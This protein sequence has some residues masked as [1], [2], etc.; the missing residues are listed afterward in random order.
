MNTLEFMPITLESR[1]VIMPFLAQEEFAISDITFGNLYIW[2]VARE[3]S[4]AISYDTLLLQTKY[5]N[6]DPYFFF[7][8]GAGDKAQAL[9]A[10]ESYVKEQGFVL[11][12]ESLESKNLPLLQR[13]FPNLKI[14]AR[15]ERFDYVYSISE[16]IALSGRKYHKKKNH[17]NQFLQ[18]YSGQWHYEPIS[19]QNI[20]AIITAA[21]QWLATHPAPTKDLQLEN[22]GIQEALQA[23][24]SLDLRGGVVYVNDEIAAF[25]F[26]EVMNDKMVVIHIE[27]A[28]PHITGAY[29]I[30]NQQL[31]ANAFSAFVYANREEDLGI[32]GLRRAKKSYNPVFMVEKYAMI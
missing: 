6:K 15:Q 21:N 20:P 18:T 14:M 11:H 30:I 22:Q 28:A 3:I 24:V 10:L 32:E 8:I 7:P 4:Y 27:K 1:A 19:Q 26:G 23:Y 12:F 2:R 25:S 9:K 31:I 16:L 17:L 5:A 29:Q 13:L